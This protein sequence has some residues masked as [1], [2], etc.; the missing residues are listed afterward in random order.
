[1]ISVFDVAR[2]G[3]EPL[4]QLLTVP[5]KRRKSLS[6][7]IGMK[8]IISALGL[9]SNTSVLAAGTFSGQVGLYSDNGE[10]DTIGVFSLGGSNA[11]NAV[12]GRGVT[13]IKWSPCGKYLYVVERMSDGVLMYD[14]RDT[15]QL[16]GWLKG[17][18][19]VTNQRMGVDVY[20]TSE[21]GNHEIW[22]GGTDGTIR[23]WTDPQH[24]EGGQEPTS[25]WKAH[26]GKR[27][28]KH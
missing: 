23:V 25:E 15:G 27:I 2:S 4:T 8:G 9:E 1:M 22:A 19:A 7:G 14:I 6:G 24:Q 13:Q 21:A 28:T 3:S 12:G 11:R 26:D 18:K 10:G 17:R 20:N 16:L 5:S